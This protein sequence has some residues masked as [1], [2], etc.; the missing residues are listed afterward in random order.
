MDENIRK[1]LEGFKDYE[2][3]KFTVQMFT[4]AL[5]IKLATGE[6]CMMDLALKELKFRGFDIDGNY[7]GVEKAS[8]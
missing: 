2:V 7:V 6:I 1:D 8:L 4:N 5:L 3:P